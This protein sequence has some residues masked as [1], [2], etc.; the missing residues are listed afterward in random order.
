MPDAT[1]APSK[2]GPA[3]QAQDARIL[4][5]RSF[6]TVEVPAETDGGASAPA[7]PTP[8]EPVEEEVW[9]FY[10]QLDF[11]VLLEDDLVTGITVTPVT[12]PEA[13]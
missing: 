5:R 9:S 3:L 2:A 7:E 11:G 6:T 4:G 10:P 8:P 1:P 13:R 12:L